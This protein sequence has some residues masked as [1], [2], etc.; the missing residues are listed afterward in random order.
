MSKFKEHL[1]MFLRGLIMGIADIIPGVSG[2]TMALI[3]G[4]Y[5]RL[6]EAINGVNRFFVSHLLKLKFGKA[7]KN[8]KKIDFALFIPL[9]LGIAIALLGLSHAIDYFLVE[10]TAITYAFFFG[11]ILGSAWLVL[12]GIKKHRK[13]GFLFAIIGFAFA[14]WLVSLEALGAN[15]SLLVLFVS[16]AV[17]ICATILPGISGSFVMVLLNQYETVIASLKNLQITNIL[18][19]ILGALVGALAF[20]KLLNFLLRKYKAETMFFLVGLMLGSLR[21][22]IEKV[23]AVTYFNTIS[24]PISLA[25][26]FSI[27]LSNFVI[28]LPILIVALIGFLIVF[29]LEKKFKH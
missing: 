17:A 18:A 10:L 4:I 21:L 27:M 20:S 28:I 23:A 25:K 29:F 12:N 1:L 2:G 6:I 19:L 11:L 22:P 24:Q 15:H 5:E 7:F 14:F 9:F 13:I 26:I 8:F 3:T 16:G